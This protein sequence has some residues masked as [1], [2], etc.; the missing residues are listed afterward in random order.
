LKERSNIGGVTFTV[1]EGELEV[2]IGNTVVIGFGTVDRSVDLL[3][4]R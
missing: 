4:R 2:F 3:G 1:V